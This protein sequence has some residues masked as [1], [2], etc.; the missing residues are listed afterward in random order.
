LIKRVVEKAKTLGVPSMVVTFEPHPF[1]FFEDVKS[2]AIPRLTRLREKFAALAACGVDYVL[3]L[4]FNQAL[5]DLSAK[6]FVQSY[7]KEAL[8]PRHIII[9]DD[10]RFGYQRQGDFAL[11]QQLGKQW[12]FEVEA[13]DTLLIDGERISST[14]VRKALADNEM[15]LVQRL[16]GHPYTMQGRVGRGDQRGRQ[17]GFPTANIF[18]HR[19]HTPL[20]GVY[21]VYMHGIAD[22]PWPGVANL[23]VRPTVDGMRTLLEVH[24]LS[25]KQELYGSYV[26]VEFCEKL[27]DEKRFPD[28]EL[29]KQQIA[30]DV[31]Q[32]RNYFSK[33]GV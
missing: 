29:L 6:A 24:L 17:F 16:L 8:Q 4:P 10:F 12:G 15:T 32:A 28:I 20:K 13:T 30:L 21:T 5:A 22:H 31:E 18:L 11:L 9:G 14:R 3:I 2:L 25:F 19:Q 7:L 1:E 27:R 33:K 23:G 26:T